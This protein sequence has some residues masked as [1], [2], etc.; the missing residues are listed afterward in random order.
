MW[1]VYSPF[2]C[3]EEHFLTPVHLSEFVPL[4]GCWKLFREVSLH[5]STFSL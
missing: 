5:G 4:V 2:R 3:S 1:F